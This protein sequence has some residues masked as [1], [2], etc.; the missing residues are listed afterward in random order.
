ML[1]HHAS[2]FVKTQWK[3]KAKPTFANIKWIRI[4]RSSLH[5]RT[6]YTIIIFKTNLCNDNYLKFFTLWGVM[7]PLCF[8]LAWCNFFG[9]SMKCPFYPFLP[10]SLVYGRP[11]TLLRLGAMLAPLHSGRS[12]RVRSITLCHSKLG[13]TV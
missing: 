8:Q 9:T 11:W 2:H 10:Y 1:N 7:S 4:E 12:R 3:L 13:P 5:R 6:F